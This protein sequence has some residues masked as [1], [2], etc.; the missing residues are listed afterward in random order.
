MDN[1]IGI[2]GE[3]YII[4]YGR[5]DLRVVTLGREGS[6]LGRELDLELE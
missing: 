6:R 5:V 1:D 3:R 2:R 4:V